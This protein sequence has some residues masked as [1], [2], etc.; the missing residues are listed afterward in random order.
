MMESMIEPIT[1]ILLILACA[2]WTRFITEDRLTVG[3]R[4]AAV[5]RFGEDGWRTYLVHCRACVSTWVGLSLATGSFFLGLIHPWWAIALVAAA[6][7]YAT[8]LLGKV[9]DAV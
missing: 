6:L 9:E 2:W 5:R 7:S 3:I 4:T 8:I 1:L